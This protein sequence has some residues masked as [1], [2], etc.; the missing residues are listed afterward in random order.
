MRLPLLVFTSADGVLAAVGG[1]R[2]SVFSQGL[3][4]GMPWRETGALNFAD[5]RWRDG[6]A[7]GHSARSEA[8]RSC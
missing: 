3:P 1:G 8:R 4:A 6:A 5:R 2:R 7:S